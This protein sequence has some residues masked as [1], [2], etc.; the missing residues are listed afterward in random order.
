MLFDAMPRP[1]WQEWF[2]DAEREAKLKPF[3]KLNL[4]QGEKLDASTIAKNNTLQWVHKAG[5]K[6]CELQ[7]TLEVDPN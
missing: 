7:E 3:C 6:L 5:V 4:C 2:K 1:I